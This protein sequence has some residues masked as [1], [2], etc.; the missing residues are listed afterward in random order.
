MTIAK[1]LMRPT[2]SMLTQL[3]RYV[4]VGFAA[5]VVDFSLL[6]AITELGVAHYYVSAAI[7]FVAGLTTNYLLSVAWVFSARTME[8]RRAE[9]AV[10]AVI[11]VAGLGLTEVILWL[12]TEWAGCDYRVAKIAAVVL[13]LGWNFCLRKA[14]LF[15]RLR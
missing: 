4:V 8:D 13:V 15:R 11:G 9:F 12:G 5:F 14:L 7:A 3:L 1:L 2:D 10:F 6:V